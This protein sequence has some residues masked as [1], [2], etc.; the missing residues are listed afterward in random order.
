[1]LNSI[2]CL[3]AVVFVD[4][5]KKKMDSKLLIKV[6]ELHIEIIVDNANIDS[7]KAKRRDKKTP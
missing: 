4:K 2:P 3:L 5:K 6:S 1:M 7:E